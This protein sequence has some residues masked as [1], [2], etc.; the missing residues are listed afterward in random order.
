MNQL[1]WLYQHSRGV[2]Q[3]YQRAREWYEKSA[4]A[5]NGSGMNQLGWIYANGLGVAKDLARA[6]E[7][8][9][10]AAAAGQASGSW[11]PALQLDS[12]QG[13]PPNFARAAQ[14]LLRGVRIQHQTAIKELQGSMDNWDRQTRVELKRE[15]QRLGFYQG[16]IDDAWDD[17][18]RRGV[19][20][21]RR[22]GLSGG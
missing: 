4:A 14:L 13:G 5:G 8:Y 10:K 22:A 15:L 3:D 1:G 19:A 11:N 17:A 20:A 2:P 18:A 12:G 6:R 9:E 16:P 21:V 7:W